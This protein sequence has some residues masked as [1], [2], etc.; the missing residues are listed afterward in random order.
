MFL[1]LINKS[2]SQEYLKKERTTKSSETE[3]LLRESTRTLKNKMYKLQRYVE[4]LQSSVDSVTNN[5]AN[6][7]SN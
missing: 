5:P 1:L 7:S 4:N 3:A 6:V 2:L